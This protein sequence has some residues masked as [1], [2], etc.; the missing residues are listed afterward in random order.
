MHTCLRCRVSC[1]GLIFILRFT[2]F[3]P[4]TA[5]C[6]AVVSAAAAAYAVVATAVVQPALQP[7]MWAARHDNKQQEAGPKLHSCGV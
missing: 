6:A 2:Y 4:D 3:M 1:A 5:V 7:R